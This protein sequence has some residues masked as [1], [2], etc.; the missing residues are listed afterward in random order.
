MLL[1]PFHINNLWEGSQISY[2][3]I[4]FYGQKRV[5]TDGQ[6]RVKTDGYQTRYLFSL[7]GTIH[8]IVW[9]KTKWILKHKGLV[10]TNPL[11]LV[12]F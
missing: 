1:L 4:S 8:A 3:N 10:Q 6:R 7:L 5:K 11:D 2:E 9:T 12:F